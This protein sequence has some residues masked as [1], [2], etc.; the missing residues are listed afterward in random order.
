M[1]KGDLTQSETRGATERTDGEVIRCAKQER[2]TR[3][4]D[5]RQTQQHAEY[6]GDFG[7]EKENCSRKH[8]AKLEIK[9]IRSEVKRKNSFDL[10]NRRLHTIEEKPHEYKVRSRAILQIGT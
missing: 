7:G 4:R 1:R 8:T 3:S 9:S 10:L 2:R 6:T 5:D